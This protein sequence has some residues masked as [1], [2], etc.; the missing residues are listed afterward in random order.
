MDKERFKKYISRIYLI[1]AYFGI[2]VLASIGNYMLLAPTNFWERLIALIS[3]V[4][5]CVI[6]FIGM[7]AVVQIIEEL[8]K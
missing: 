1:L 3:S 7:I 2:P 6:V 8:K 5:V 4:I